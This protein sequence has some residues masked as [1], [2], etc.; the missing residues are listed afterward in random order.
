VSWSPDGSRFGFI[1]DG[2]VWTAASDGTDVRPLTTFAL[3]G[4]SNA[5]WSPDGRWIAVIATH[6]LWTMRSDGT[7]QRWLALGLADSVYEAVWSPDS[8][9][10]AVPTYSDATASG[11]HSRVLLV[12]PDGGPAVLVDDAVG[13]GWS[14]D[15]RFLVVT[16][17]VPSGIDT[18]SLA[19]MNAD[20][21]GRS[22]LG[23]TGL[24]QTAPRFVK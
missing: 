24:D 17:S 10:L 18:G 15:G 21:S 6:G 5:I 23:T 11:Q 20:G 4:A 16:D 22:D 3:G 7:E 13:P 19:V 8:S 9:R 12:R 2:N 1:R 14:P